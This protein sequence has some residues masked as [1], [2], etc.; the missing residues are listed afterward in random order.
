MHTALDV[1]EFLESIEIVSLE[2]RAGSIGDS[3]SGR[4]GKTAF[5]HFWEEPDHVE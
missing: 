3:S 4:R 5:W 2:I 1:D